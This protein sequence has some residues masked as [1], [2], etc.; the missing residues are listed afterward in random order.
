MARKIIPASRSLLARSRCSVIY[1]YI[2][3]YNRET[4][5]NTNGYG[6]SFRSVQAFFFFLYA[7]TFVKSRRVTRRKARLA[8]WIH[9]VKLNLYNIY[10]YTSP[11]KYYILIRRF[12]ERRGGISE[13]K[14]KR[15]IIRECIEI[16]YINIESIIGIAEHVFIYRIV[17][18]S[19][20]MNDC[21]FSW[22]VLHLN[23]A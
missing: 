22:N 14:K 9:I 15:E 18:I 17:R 16:L 8:C 2:I 5:A 21:T 19:H 11:Y 10:T 20:R 1:I 13:K 6:G 7:P 23:F 4:F 12:S 3:L